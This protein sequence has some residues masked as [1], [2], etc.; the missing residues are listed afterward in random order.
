MDEHYGV[1]P[2]IKRQCLMFTFVTSW[3]S[4]AFSYVQS[5][6]ELVQK[7][8][9]R[10]KSSMRGQMQIFLLDFHLLMSKVGG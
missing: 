7:L 2:S 1:I 8:H 5:L 3:R 9:E 6:M 10:L 4:S